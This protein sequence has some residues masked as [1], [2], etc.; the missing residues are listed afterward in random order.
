MTDFL[1]SKSK[2]TLK[3]STSSDNFTINSGI[4]L[5]VDGS[6]GIDTAKI[7][8]S[9]ITDIGAYD[10]VY[11]STTIAS[12]GI[13]SG[14]FTSFESITIY[15]DSTNDT[16]RF[17]SGDV[18]PNIFVSAGL[19]TDRLILPYTHVTTE[20]FNV[21]K[22]IDSGQTKK[23]LVSF[24]GGSFL[25]DNFEELQL[26]DGYPSASQRRN[27]S[28]DFDVLFNLTKVIGTKFNDDH[29]GFNSPSSQ[30]LWIDENGINLG[31]QGQ[32]KPLSIEGIEYIQFFSSTLYVPQGN[33]VSVPYENGTLYG[34]DSL[35]FVT[36]NSIKVIQV[37]NLNLATFKTLAAVIPDLTPP[38]I[39]INSNYS[40]LSIGQSAT[41]TFTLSES[42]INFTAADVIVSGGAL[43]N[44]SGNGSNY[45]ALFTPTANSNTN[46]VLRVESGAFTDA[47]GNSNLDG[48][49][50]DNLVTLKVNTVP[51]DSTPPTVTIIGTTNTLKYS[52]SATLTF[53]LSE[54]S[55]NFTI[56]DIS[57]S[58]GTL[59]N[60]SG[61][62]GIYKVTFTPSTNSSVDGTVSI[63]SG[64]FSDA[65]GNLNTDGL[66]ANNKWTFARTVTVLN[67][68]HT[69]SVIVDKGVLSSSAMLLKG[70]NESITYTDGIITKH[71]VE[72]SGMSFDYAQIDS[73]IT[74]VI[75]DDE[76][77]TEF[78][79]ELTDAAPSTVNLTY[80]DAVTL[81]GLLNI[82]SI[83]IN[84]AG[85]DGNFVN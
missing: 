12:T 17:I 6:T 85:L 14:K 35:Q 16:I 71:S 26:N 31:F 77:T 34:I 78:R 65:A 58:G 2:T 7:Y 50:S 61:S 1:I 25:A 33:L 22:S 40:S 13:T 69:L 18:Q 41:I 4:E 51:I 63:A 74:T 53:L 67:E 36:F 75:R 20:N 15:G 59:S 29:L 57:Y 44:F 64:V 3:G 23:F 80:Q 43:S 32:S 27:L 73:L 72:Y 37:P 39:S 62:G 38:T 55:T 68:K 11:S 79:K 10:K 28:I 19:G 56:S 46:G 30:Y 21:Q 47:A 81:V 84:L 9:G 48:T 45:T 66:D 52:E 76:F 5:D 8:V 42:S 54:T 49:D 83:L 82:D 60:F 24:Q 70:L